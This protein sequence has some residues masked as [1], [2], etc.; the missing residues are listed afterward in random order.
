MTIQLESIDLKKEDLLFPKSFIK[1]LGGKDKARLALLDIIDMYFKTDY[2]N[3]A[4]L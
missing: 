3:E 1:R 4:E 2:I